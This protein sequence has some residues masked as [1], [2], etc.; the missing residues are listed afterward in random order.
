MNGAKASTVVATMSSNPVTHR[1]MA[2]GTSQRRFES[3]RHHPRA[4]SAIDPN[5]LPNTISPRWILPRFS[6]TQLLLPF[7]R[8]AFRYSG[9]AHDQD[10]D[11]AAKKGRVSLHRAIHD[12]F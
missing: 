4:R 5:V 3:L 2:N 9:L 8:C 11:A 12:R 7:R 6:S 10:I 1:K